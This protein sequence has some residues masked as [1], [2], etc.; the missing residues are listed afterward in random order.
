[1]IT[2][3]F[4]FVYNIYFNIFMIFGESILKG[5]INTKMFEAYLLS[6]KQFNFMLNE[7]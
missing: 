5:K 4:I 6:Y 3:F 2:S 7:I 1:M